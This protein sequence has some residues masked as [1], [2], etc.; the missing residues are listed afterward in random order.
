MLV[1]IIIGK[2][3]LF[4]FLLFYFFTFKLNIKRKWQD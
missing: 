2:K 1:G 3:A 4:T